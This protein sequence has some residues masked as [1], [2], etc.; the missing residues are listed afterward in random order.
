LEVN[1]KGG[2][3]EQVEDVVQPIQPPTVFPDFLAVVVRTVR[4]PGEATG[5][6]GH[7][8]PKKGLSLWAAK[9]IAGGFLRWPAMLPLTGRSGL[10]LLV[11]GLLC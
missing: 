7:G 2:R 1:A 8:Y 3:A 5:I 6:A 10:F 9:F 4:V 11:G